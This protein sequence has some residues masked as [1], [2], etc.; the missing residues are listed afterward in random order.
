VFEAAPMIDESALVICLEPT[1]NTLQ[2]GCLGNINA[3]TVFEGKAAH[4]A[5]PWL[6]VNAIALALEGLRDVLELPP[7][8]VDVDGLVFREVVSVTQID[9]CGNASNVIPGRVECTLN[10]RFAPT[11]TQAEAEGRLRELVGREIE[12]VQSARAAHV[13]L[14]SPLVEHL[15]EVGSFAVEPKQAWTN[16]ADFA[17]RGLDAL[18]LGPG[19]TRYAHAADERVE[20]S[21]LARTF[22]ALQRF[23]GA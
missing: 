2:L 15:R 11:R 1:D 17:A 21:Q 13:A 6:G 22:D 12:I 16:V 23:L 14:H 20:I 7:N 5:R 19:S 4:S 10:Y 8:D 3:K 9:D 18:N